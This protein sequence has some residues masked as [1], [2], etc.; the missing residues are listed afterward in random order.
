MWTH[1]DLWYRVG[2]LDSTGVTWG[3]SQQDGSSGHAPSIALTKEG[4]VLVVHGNRD[5]DG[6]NWSD[7]YYRVGWIDP[8]GDQN[9]SITWKSDIIHWNVG[10][11]VS[12][13]M[14]D[15]GVIVGVHE[16]GRGGDGLYYRVGHFKNPALGDF[17]IEW[18]SGPWGIRYET[19]V[20]PGIAINNHDQIVEVHQVPNETLLHYRRGHLS[21]GVISFGDSRRYDNHAESPAVALLDNGLVLEVHQ[22][23]GLISR[24]GK[25]S[26]PTEIEWLT[27]IKV[28]DKERV[29]Q[30]TIATNGV[31][32][33]QAYYD[34]S[35][36]KVPELYYSIANICDGFQTG[37]NDLDDVPVRMEGISATPLE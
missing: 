16:A 30:S 28:D 4:D 32:A 21:G 25:L 11:H 2:K 37:E 26:H 12:I 7:L 35:D 31:H 33:I 15:N 27:P 8:N 24:T 20:N 6:K 22:L 13:A 14:N 29:A 34:W 18:A 1:G 36:G 3:P 17:S 5:R 19:G 23:G 10:F 9:Q